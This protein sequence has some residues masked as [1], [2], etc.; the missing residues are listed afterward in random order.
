MDSV[1][2][3]VQKHYSQT[4]V[5]DF[6]PL[7]CK[8]VR[9]AMIDRGLCRTHINQRINRIRRIFK[10]GVENELVPSGILH[11]LQAVAPLKRGR[12]PAP[13][14]EPVRPVP[15]AHVDAVLPRVARQIAA[16][17]ELQRLSGMR[18]GEVVLIRPGEVDRSGAV[19]VYRPKQHKTAYR[20]F[21]REIYLGPKAQGVLAP[22]L[23]RDANSYCFSP[24]EAEAER[25]ANRR[26]N[27]QSPMT[28]SQAG[29][30][31]KRQPK[32]PKR[33]RYDVDSYRRAITYAI[34]KAEVP[35]WHP[36]QLRHNCATR[37]RREYGLDIAQV[38]LGHAS[39]NITE[40]Y[41]EADRIRAIEVMARAG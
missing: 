12:S 5:R 14:S 26:V 22:W 10:W 20:G 21:Q 34:K 28:P 30:K 40:V 35:S 3:E 17:I 39:A 25:N 4:C 24:A 36:H 13:E 8:T 27:R 16:M 11:A 1:I 31:P 7:A 33:D 6:G 9:Q 19:W 29:R 41:A 15:D 23:L 32:R 18:S 38:I 2:T 37:M